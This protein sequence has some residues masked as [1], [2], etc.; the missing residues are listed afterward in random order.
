[1]SILLVTDGASRKD[2]AE[3]LILLNRDAKHAPNVIEPSTMRGVPTMWSIAH[4]RIN[5]VLDDWEA[6]N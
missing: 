6:A 3:T 1:M 5:A 2:L 4:A